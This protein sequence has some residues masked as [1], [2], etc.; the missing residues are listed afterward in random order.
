MPAR[1]ALLA[2]LL[3]LGLLPACASIPNNQGYIADAELVAG[4]QPGVDN[5]QS[6]Q[7]ALGRP[8]LSGQWS[9]DVW[10][11]VSRNTGQFAARRPRPKSQEILIVRFA[12]DGSVAAVERRGLEKVANIS[13]E[14]DKTPT[15]GREEGLLGEI[16]GNIGAVGA[17][18][19]AGG[20]AG[21]PE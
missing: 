20:G 16:F 11:Y 17:I 3:G 9:D 4:V 8:T 2:A 10:Y 15:L 19:G 21:G 14:S 18:P 5:R 6:V 7:K 13:P 12:A 1:P